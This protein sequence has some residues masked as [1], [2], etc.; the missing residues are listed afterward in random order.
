MRARREGVEARVATFNGDWREL[1]RLI[2]AQRWRVAFF[3]VAEDEINYRR[4]FN[5]NDLAGL[6]MEL[7]PGVRP[8]ARAR[9]RHAARRRDRGLRID[10]IDGLFDP[11]AYLAALR[12]H[13][14]KPFYLVVE[15][16]LAAARAACER[17]GRSRAA[18]ATTSS[19]SSLGSP[20]RPVRGGRV[21]R[22]LPDLRRRRRRASR[23]SRRCA[24]FGSWTTRWR[25]NCRARPR[26]GAP[27]SSSPMT[28]DLTRATLQR[29]IRQTIANF[30]VYRTYVDLAGALDDADLRDLAW[31]IAGARRATPTPPVRVRLPRACADRDAGGLA[32][33]GA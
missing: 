6:R 31:A 30:P 20:D 18:P 7:A 17:T 14:E 33:E 10:H 23:R 19:I 22:D 28:A 3:R 8:R 4:F 29:A 21:R 13:A 12:E 27:R 5:I 1:D 25:A 26:R 15:K 24:S 16:I 2:E 32:G 9:L 11:K